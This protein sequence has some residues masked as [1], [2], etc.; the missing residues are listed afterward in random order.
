MFK[1]RDRGRPSS[2]PSSFAEDD[3]G[4]LKASE[5]ARKR[6]GLRKAQPVASPAWRSAHEA[7][8]AKNKEAAEI[9]AKNVA[10]TFTPAGE[11]KKRASMGGSSS[12]KK[13]RK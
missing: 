4:R 1:N 13:P 8:S 2:T 10:G 5:G 6:A 7:S 11:V 3:R 12:V 9:Q